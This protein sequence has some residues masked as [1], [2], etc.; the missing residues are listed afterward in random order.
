MFTYCP[1]YSQ[2]VFCCVV[3][4]SL[5]IFL[6]HDAAWN[7][8]HAINEPPYPVD[9]SFLLTKKLHE[10]RYLCACPGSDDKHAVN[11]SQID[12]ASLRSWPAISWVGSAASQQ[13]P[14]NSR[15]SRSNFARK[16][17]FSAWKY[18]QDPNAGNSQVAVSSVFTLTVGSLLQM[19]EAATAKALLPTVDSWMDGTTRRL[20]ASQS[21]AAAAARTT[22]TMLL[23]VWLAAWRRG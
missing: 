13:D 4:L 17:V 16:N 21:T 8:Q 18:K 5:W 19:C 1:N 6:P 3:F 12:T 20:S 14:A 10:D 9:S 2:L 22:T 11:F 15:T 23:V 7:C